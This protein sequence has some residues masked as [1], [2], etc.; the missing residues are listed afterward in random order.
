MIMIIGDAEDARR[1]LSS[2]MITII[3]D[4]DNGD[5]EI[6]GAEDAQSTLSS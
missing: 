3:M 1:W 4:D 5:E 2:M 6:G